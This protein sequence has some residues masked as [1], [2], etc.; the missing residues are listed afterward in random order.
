MEIRTSGPH[1]TLGAERRF[2]NQGFRNAVRLSGHLRFTTRKH[3]RADRRES[4]RS[5][6]PYAPPEPST[7]QTIRASLLAKATTATF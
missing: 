6:K 4:L 7:A 5:A 3:H 1:K 2:L